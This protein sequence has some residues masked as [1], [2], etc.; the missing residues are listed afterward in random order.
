MG[1]PIP[2][3]KVVEQAAFKQWTPG[4]PAVCGPARQGFQAGKGD[5]LRTAPTDDGRIGEVDGGPVII[6]RPS[7]PKIVAFGFHPALSAMRYE[8]THAAAVRQSL[9][10]DLARD[11]PPLGNH[12]AA[13]WERSDRRSDRTRPPNQVKVTAEDGTALAVHACATARSISSPARPGRCASSRATA[14][15]STR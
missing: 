13:A 9:A 2:V 14:S 5:R 15:T 11:L 12:A 10:L 8:L 7:K 1:S 4:H 3:R 6:A